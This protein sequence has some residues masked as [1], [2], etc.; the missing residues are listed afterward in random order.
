MSLKVADKFKDSSVSYR[1]GNKM[2]HIP[3]LADATS[4]QLKDLAEGNHPGVI[5]E[6]K[7]SQAKKA[8]GSS[9]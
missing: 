7:S 3:K 6:A 2:I 9:S 1:K 5:K 8:Q 4:G